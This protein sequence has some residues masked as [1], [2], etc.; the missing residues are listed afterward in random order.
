MIDVRNIVSPRKAAYRRPTTGPRIVSVGTAT[1][2]RK[3]TQ[4][5]V[6]DLFQ[7]KDPKV[8]RLFQSNHIDTRYLYLPDA[9][10]GRMAEETNQGLLDRHLDGALEIGPRAIEECLQP[11][12]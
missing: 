11:L 12:G 5:E 8:R 6:I 7:E 2:P 1:P 3:Y 9:I 10:D 4:D